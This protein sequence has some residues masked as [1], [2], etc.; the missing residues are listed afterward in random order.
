MGMSACF[1]I[2]GTD[3]G[4]GKTVFAAALCQHLGA[5]YWKPVQAGLEHFQQKWEPVL[6]P[7]MRKNKEL[8]PFHDSVLNGNALD[9]ETD[10]QTVQRLTKHGADKFLPEAYR[11][12]APLSPHRAAALEGVV[13]ETEKLALPAVDAPLVVE[14]A[15]GV[16]VPLRGDW[17]YADQ[18]A[19]WGK[20][21]I[22]C[23]RTALGTINHT[24]LS[25]EALRSRNV[26]VHGV[27]FI[28]DDEPE[29]MQA[30]ASI[31][32]VTVLGRLA[33]LDDV[34]PGALKQAFTAGFEG[35]A[36]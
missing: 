31:G 36:P 17:L 30:I 23:A 4:I 5:A 6:R 1:I 21:V 12:K 35:F 27:A 19:H 14:G 15:G 13:I 34:T 11:L 25:L 9:Y 28:G 18:F 22:L 20:P 8:E 26:P 33:K 10:T 29:T 7:E 2:T 3:T 32:R 24:L 16:L